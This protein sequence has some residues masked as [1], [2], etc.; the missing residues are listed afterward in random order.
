VN[1]SALVSNSATLLP[2]YSVTVMAVLIVDVHA[3][4]AGVSPWERPPRHLRGLGVDL[5]DM[6]RVNSAIHR[7]FCESR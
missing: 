1:F 3:A 4:A 5:A 6:P 7:L 2:R